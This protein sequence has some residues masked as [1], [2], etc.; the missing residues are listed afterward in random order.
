ME[1]VYSYI[2]H[3]WE[4][5]IWNGTVFL[6]YLLHT[7]IR[8]FCLDSNLHR[9]RQKDFHVFAHYEREYIGFE[10]NYAKYCLPIL[11]FIKMQKSLFLHHF[12]EEPKRVYILIL[13]RQPHVF[14]YGF[15]VSH[16]FFPGHPGV[17]IFH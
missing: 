5:I 17:L 7:E 3:P 8:I 15:S 11:R 12:F 9:K 6:Y 4:K 2:L 16:H 14:P 1:K 10:S 13:T